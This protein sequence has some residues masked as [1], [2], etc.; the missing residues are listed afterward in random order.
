MATTADE[1]W[2]LLGELIQAQ[3][4]TERQLKEQGEAA[5]RRSQ[6]ANHRFQAQ[7][8]EADRRF[9]EQREEADRRF[10]KT[11]RQIR[12]LGK[13]IG[14]LGQKFGSFTEGLAL[15]SM[16]TILREKFG[17]EVV[18][19]SVRVS[20]QGKHI[21]LDVMAYAN[22]DV[23]TAI[24]VEVK[25]H[26]RSESIGQLIN[27]LQGFREFF[28]EH[29]DKKLYGIL[30]AVDLSNAVR[31]EVLKAG[32]YTARIRDEIFE[33]DTPATFQPRIW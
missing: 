2:Q 26:A 4:E 27:H 8:E 23:K 6:E 11:D 32:L 24:I 21:E 19:P 5:E 25:S 12:E 9:Q 10:Q 1:V 30:A 17:M 33:L 7:R 14:G 29:Q 15:P 31:E 16:E 3:K 22:G 20:K 18:T 13:Q 28:P